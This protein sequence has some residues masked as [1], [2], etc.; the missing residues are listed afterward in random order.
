M[1][2]Y[3]VFGRELSILD[4]GDFVTC[5]GV[6]RTY[7]QAVAAKTKAEDEACKRWTEAFNRDGKQGAYVDFDHAPERR[8]DVEL[9]VIPLE[10]NKPCRKWLGGYAD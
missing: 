9:E 1:T 6:Y 5:Y 10:M 2:V 7:E 8:E 4:Y 3:M